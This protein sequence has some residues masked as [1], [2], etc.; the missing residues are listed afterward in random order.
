[1]RFRW[2]AAVA[3]LAL[4]GQAQAAEVKPAVVYDLGGKF[5]KSFNQAAYMGAERFKTETGIEYKD[6]EIQNDSQREQAFRK[7]AR[8]GYNPIIGTGFSMEAAMKKVAAEFPET[9]FG[10]I[11]MVVELPNV[12]S[13]VFKEE[14]GSYLVASGRDGLEDQ[15]VA[16][17]R[18]TS[19]HR[20][21]AWQAAGCGTVDPSIQVF[22]TDRDTGAAWNDP[23]GRRARGADR[24]GRGRGLPRR[25]RHRHRRAAGRG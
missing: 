2:L 14:E 12:R 25:R 23:V 11:D 22:R 18:R 5:D 6:F 16:R 17:R 13:I 4:L 10:I 3:A 8:D 20:K 21:F 1:M 24:A 19:A 15:E 9:Q 7:F